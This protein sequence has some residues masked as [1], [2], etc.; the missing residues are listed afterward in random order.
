ME[1][2]VDNWKEALGYLAPLFII[3]SMMQQNLTHV[4]LLMI[5]G[6]ITFVIYGYLI[7]AMPVVVANAL[8]CS[9]TIFYLLK[10]KVSLT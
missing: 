4:R 7:G 9:V 6:C 2:L 3:L 10:P 8:I 5:L 1:W